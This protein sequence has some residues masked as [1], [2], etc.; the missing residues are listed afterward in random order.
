MYLTLFT[1]Y[2]L[3]LLPSRHL[4]SRKK[5]EEKEQKER[6]KKRKEERKRERKTETISA[7]EKA[8]AI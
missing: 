7:A 5:R 1:N 2:T 3:I 8:M 6:K 4:P